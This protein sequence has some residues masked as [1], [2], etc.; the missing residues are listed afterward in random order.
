MEYLHYEPIVKSAASINKFAGGSLSDSVKTY[1]SAK[2]NQD[3]KVGSAIHF[4]AP[5]A[6]LII[7]SAVKFTKLGILLAV[8]TAGSNGT[9]ESWIGDF[10]GR[11]TN[12]VKSQIESG[13]RVSYD[14]VDN[15]VDATVSNSSS[16]VKSSQLTNR[17]VRLFKL[18]TLNKTADSNLLERFRRS[19]P[20]LSEVKRNAVRRTAFQLL[21]AAIGLVVKIILLSAGLALIGDLGRKIIGL[22]SALDQDAKPG[23]FSG[24]DTTNS[25]QQ[26]SS[27][28][29]SP[30]SSEKRNSSTPWIEP[31]ANNRQSIQNLLVDFTHEVYPNLNIPDSKIISSPNVNA[32]VEEILGYNQHIP[33]SRFIFLPKHFD[34]KK[35]IVDYFISTIK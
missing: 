3:D 26:T 20:F 13:N 18:A 15:L 2:I 27:D 24:T 17:D 31:V 29:A 33:S 21:G 32:I 19:L 16:I 34:S 10:I 14:E 12:P 7:L 35:E 5:S 23:Q 4:L 1:I 28:S 8:I 22:P 11:I 6:I 9:V 25:N 30:S